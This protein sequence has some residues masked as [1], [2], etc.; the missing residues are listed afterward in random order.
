MAIHLIVTS[1][2]ANHNVGERIKDSADVARILGSHQRM[3][4]VKIEAPDEPKAEPKVE[5]ANPKK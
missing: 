4:V 3:H 5:A 1:P 2:F